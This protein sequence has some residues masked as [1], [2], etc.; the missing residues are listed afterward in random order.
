MVNAKDVAKVMARGYITMNSNKKWMW[1]DSKPRL[2]R[3]G[4]WY[5]AT[6]LSSKR[7]PTSLDYIFEIE[8][9]EDYRKSCIKCGK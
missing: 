7:Y 3:E 5:N 2:D 4:H 8:P 6:N 1:W 9:V